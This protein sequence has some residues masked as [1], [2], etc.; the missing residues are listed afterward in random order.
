LTEEKEHLPRLVSYIDQ[1]NIFGKWKAAH[2]N[3][4]KKS[5]KSVGIVQIRKA[6]EGEESDV[7]RTEAPK[8]IAGWSWNGITFCSK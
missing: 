7:C 2:Y 5:A 1:A 3:K 6:R 8:K 4:R